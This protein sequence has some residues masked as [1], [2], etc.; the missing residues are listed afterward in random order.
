MGTSSRAVTNCKP[1]EADDSWDVLRHIFWTR[2][3]D[4]ETIAPRPRVPQGCLHVNFD[5]L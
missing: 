1:Q 4:T 5:L 2:P 3:N